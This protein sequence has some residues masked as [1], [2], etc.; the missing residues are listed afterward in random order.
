MMAAERCERYRRIFFG[1][2][3]EGKSY[4]GGAENIKPACNIKL[5]LNRKIKG[6]SGT[7]KNK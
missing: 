4:S 5:K 7:E 1:L 3:T 2:E 6:F